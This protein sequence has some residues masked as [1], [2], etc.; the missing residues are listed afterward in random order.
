VE[1]RRAAS[2]NRRLTASRR[3][4]AARPP[5]TTLH[6]RQRLPQACAWSYCPARTANASTPAGRVADRCFGPAR[7]AAWEVVPRARRRRLPIG[8]MLRAKR[9][10]ATSSGLRLNDRWDVQL[11][12][13]GR[14]RLRRQLHRAELRQTGVSEGTCATPR[15]RSGRQLGALGPASDA[16]RNGGSPGFRRNGRSEGSWGWEVSGQYI[17][18]Y[19]AGAV[20]RACWF[21]GDPA[22]TQSAP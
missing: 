11:A 6:R 8:A 2:G 9:W 15:K 13:A 5:A 16:S 22:I 12:R 14:A 4:V 18:C 19:Q 1:T 17:V 20:F 21:L 3:N 7:E 10:A